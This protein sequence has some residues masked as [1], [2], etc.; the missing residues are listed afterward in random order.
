MQNAEPRADGG[1]RVLALLL[2]AVEPLGFAWYASGV[3]TR[4]VD[5]GA[6]AVGLLLLRVA[7]TAIGMAAGLRLWREHDA[8]IPLAI[9]ALAA[10]ALTTLITALVPAL[11]IMRPPGTRGPIVLALLAYDAAWIGYLWLR[12]HR[13]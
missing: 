1:L 8:G 6:L 5:R 9:L 4:V 13:R 3:L 12:Q 2:L 7:V 10:G 11:P